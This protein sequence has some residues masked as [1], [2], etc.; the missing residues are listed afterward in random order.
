VT[1][2]SLSE[3]GGTL[4]QALA[5]A[6]IPATSGRSYLPALGD[7]HAQNQRK[8]SFLP[9]ILYTVT[10]DQLAILRKSFPMDTKNGLSTMLGQLENRGLRTE[11]SFS[12]GTQTLWRMSVYPVD[13]DPNHFSVG[14]YGEAVPDWSNG[15]AMAYLG[16]RPLPIRAGADTRVG[17]ETTPTGRILDGILRALNVETR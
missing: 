10:S 1:L 11:E 3:T 14:F 8:G 15:Q 9:A 12:P 4:N 5:S 17:G 16:D 7:R 13:G 2:A 6:G